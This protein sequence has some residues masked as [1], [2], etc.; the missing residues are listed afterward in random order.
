MNWQGAAEEDGAEGT[1]GGATGQP[2][3]TVAAL[4]GS[5]ETAAAAQAHQQ[6]GAQSRG[7]LRLPGQSQVHG[8]HTLPPRPLRQ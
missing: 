1:D 4:A 3:R 6:G 7:H 2:G 8:R 5:A